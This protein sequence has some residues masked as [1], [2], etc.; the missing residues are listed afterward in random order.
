VPEAEMIDAADS[1]FLVLGTAIAG[2]DGPT[3]TLQVWTPRGT[4]W[5]RLGVDTGQG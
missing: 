3:Q 1:Q 4:Q 5:L 2:V